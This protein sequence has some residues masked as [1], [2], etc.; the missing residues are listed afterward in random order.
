MKDYNPP[1][2]NKNRTEYIPRVRITPNQKR[3]LMEAYE[4]TYHSSLAA[5]IREKVFQANHGFSQK[6]KIDNLRELA[7]FQT[8]LSRVGNNINQVAKAHNIYRNGQM[9]SEE[10]KLL[11]EL[12]TLHKQI[13]YQLHKVRL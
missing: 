2:F 12:I 3:E 7:Q 9:Q 6:T 13:L 5:F 1:T 8:E 4:E 11:Q 10:K